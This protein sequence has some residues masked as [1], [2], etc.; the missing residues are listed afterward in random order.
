MERLVH[1]RLRHRDIVLEASRYRRPHRMHQPE[2]S[3]TVSD[4]LHYDPHRHQIEDLVQVLVL[5]FHLLVNAVKMLRATVYVVFDAYLIKRLLYLRHDLLD[6]FLTFLLALI[7]LFGELVVSFGLKELQRDIL[8]LHLHRIDTE[9]CS[10]RRVYV[11][12]LPAFLDY[13]VMRH[14]VDS[15]QVVKPVRKL[16]DEDSDI[17]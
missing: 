12:R 15:P 16:D 6:G 2:H 13:L 3:V 10:E 1:V 5:V 11:Q 9:S 14:I 7:H 4:C 17:F 8:E